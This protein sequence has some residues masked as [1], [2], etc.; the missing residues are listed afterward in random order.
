MKRII[1]LSIAIFVILSLIAAASTDLSYLGNFPRIF[2]EDGDL[3][4]NLVVGKSAKAEDVL[5]AIDVVTMLQYELNE[6]YSVSEK[7]EITKFDTEIKDV[8]A[9]N[10]I[11]IGGPCA[12]SVAAELMNY[13]SNCLEGFEAGK[14]FI[15]VYKHDNGNIAILAA[16]ATALDTR[17]VTLVLTNHEDY[18]LEGMFMEVSGVSLHD[19]EVEQK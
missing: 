19:V 3:D 4:V 14:G 8:E 16:G 18:N 12:N 13:P 7:V 2:M 6:E 17:R 1:S 15:R 10:L 5:G 9:Q 11:V